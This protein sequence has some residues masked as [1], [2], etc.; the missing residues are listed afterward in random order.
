MSTWRYYFSLLRS[1]PMAYVVASVLSIGAFGIPLL[2]GLALREVF[3]A[4]IGEAQIDFNVWVLLAIWAAVAIS[5]VGLAQPASGLAF[6]YVNNRLKTLLEANLLRGMLTSPRSPVRLSS[7]DVINRFRDDTDAI[8]EPVLIPAIMSGYAVVITGAVIV[9][10]RVN[11]VIALV[12]FL[13]SLLVIVVTRLAGARLQAYREAAREATSRTTGALGELLTGV[14]SIQVATTET[15]AT[16]H[17]DR[18]SDVRRRAA[19]RE[20]ALEAVLDSLYGTTLPLTTGAIL[21]A[22][23]PLMRDGTFTVGDFALFVSIV[24]AGFVSYFPTWLGQQL[25]NLKRAEVSFQ[26]LFDLLPYRPRGDV[27]RP[28]KLYLRDEPPQVRHARR[29]DSDRL[30]VLDVRNLTVKHATSGQGISNFSLRLERG[31]FTVLTG[32]IGSGKST[33]LQGLLGLIPME[34]GETLWNG[35]RVEEPRSI[36]VPPRCAYTPQDPRL[37]SETVRENVLLG[38]SENDAALEK[39]LHLAVMERDVDELE[40]G[41]DTVV[42]PR[43]VRLSGGQIIR[44]AAARMFVREPELMVFDDLSS[45]LDVETEQKLWQRVSEMVGVTSLVVSHR[46]AA[47]HRADH[48]IVLKDGRVEAEGTLAELLRT[49]EEMQ[50]LWAGDIGEAE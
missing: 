2:A 7:G 47:Y 30:R 15:H 50:R 40:S 33:V 13:P 34:S 44:T 46:P 19:L 36:F 12:A 4:M 43:G 28:T 49:S 38:I 1:T 23:A 17:F 24:T 39:A 48:I 8:T 22:G 10:I 3:D 5:H 29:A 9:M 41:L 25:A 27:V 14:Q 42:G 11:V 45:A 26:R 37:F 16:R 6:W 31:S 35:E 20:G 32:R 21:L 18:R